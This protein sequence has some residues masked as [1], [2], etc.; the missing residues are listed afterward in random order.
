MSVLA[1]ARNDH[2]QDQEDVTFRARNR[3]TAALAGATVV[4]GLMCS[5]E[6]MACGDSAD[7]G[8]QAAGTQSP[9]SVDRLDAI[10]AARQTLAVQQDRMVELASRLLRHQEEV[11]QLE[12]QIVSRK[13]T[14]ESAKA[15][16]AKAKLTREAAELGLK[17]YTEQTYPQDLALADLEIKLAQEEVAAAREETKTAEEHLAKIKNAATGSV[18]DITFE[19]NF[20]RNVLAARL[21]ELKAGLSLQ[22]AES[23]KKVLVDY[24]KRKTEKELMSEVEKCR[25]D[26]LATKATWELEQSK[27]T[28]LERAAKRDIPAD[29]KRA[30]VLLDRAIDVQEQVRQKLALSTGQQSLAEGLANEIKD[31]TSELRALVDEADGIRAAVQFDLVKPQIHRA[32]ER[33]A[34]PKK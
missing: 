32:A 30:L 12:D 3:V 26:E 23:K 29:L 18:A 28:A 16:Y 22:Q 25:S 21:N 7:S 34:S 17:T 15:R 13:T 24:T 5:L 8:A 27:S 20:E 1:C 19:F 14:V 31:L 10:S 6:P 11:R 33:A 2:K 9:A 4:T